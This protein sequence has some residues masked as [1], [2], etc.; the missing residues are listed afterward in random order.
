MLPLLAFQRN[1]WKKNLPYLNVWK[2]FTGQSCVRCGANK[3]CLESHG[4][5]W[6]SYLAF[7]RSCPGE[8]LFSRFS[9]LTSSSSYGISLK[10]PLR[11]MLKTSA[12]NL[13]DREVKL[14]GNAW[15]DGRIDGGALTPIGFGVNRSFVDTSLVSSFNFF[16]SWWWVRGDWCASKLKIDNSI[17]FLPLQLMVL[18]F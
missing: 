15:M 6:N 17:S 13:W 12:E 9:C 3:N 8:S 16:V 10:T 1:T 4:A 18:S 2:P 14:S 11:E 5:T 7:E